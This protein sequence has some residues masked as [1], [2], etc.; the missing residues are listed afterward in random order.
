MGGMEIVLSHLRI[1]IPLG[2]PD[3]T[4]ALI[5]CRQ[6]ALFPCKL[7]VSG[8]FL[9]KKVFRKLKTEISS[10]RLGFPSFLF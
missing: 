7:S 9:D 8:Q 4:M 3:D 10:L 1:V 2:G 6:T 5:L